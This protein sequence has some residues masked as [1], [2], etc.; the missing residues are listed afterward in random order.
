MQTTPYVQRVIDAIDLLLDGDEDGA[1]ALLQSPASTEDI[2][3]S[4]SLV[5]QLLLSIDAEE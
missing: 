4:K 2:E 1:Q 5:D 3:M